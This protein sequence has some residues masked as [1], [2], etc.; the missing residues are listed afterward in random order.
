M[1]PALSYMCEV[2]SILSRPD[3]VTSLHIYGRFNFRI[4]DLKGGEFFK[5]VLLAYY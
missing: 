1:V 5:V 2:S 3:V 4:K